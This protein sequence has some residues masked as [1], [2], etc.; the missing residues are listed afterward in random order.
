MVKVNSLLLMV[1]EKSAAEFER[2]VT[3][4]RESGQPSVADAVQQA[5]HAIAQHTQNPLRV[6]N[7]KLAYTG[8]SCPSF[9]NFFHFQF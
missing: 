1:R 3:C 9:F 5:A 8:H 6:G 2:F 7:G 4:L